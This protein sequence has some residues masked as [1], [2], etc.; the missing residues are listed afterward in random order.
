M[1]YTHYNIVLV[2]DNSGTKNL[3][4]PITNIWHVHDP[5][6]QGGLACFQNNTENICFIVEIAMEFAE[7]HY[8]YH[9]IVLC[10]EHIS[11]PP[12]VHA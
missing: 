9:N 4:V 3:N 12:G 7:H 1:H 5:L 11:D 6:W 8:T 2:Q 10:D